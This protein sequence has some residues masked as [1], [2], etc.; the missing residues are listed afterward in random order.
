MRQIIIIFSFIVVFGCT[1]KNDKK[2]DTFVYC[3][4]G[5]PSVFNPQLATDGP[6]FNASSK[7]IYNRLTAFKPGSTEVVGELA[8]NWEVSADGKRVKFK[9]RPDVWFHEQFG[10]K[11][12][13][14]FNADDV[15]FTFNRML[16]Q[17]HPFHSVNGGSY[18]YFLSMDLGNQILELN[19]LGEHEVEFVLKSPDAPFV[20]NMAMDFASVLSKE[21]ADFLAAKNEKEKID[22]QPIGTGPYVFKKYVKDSTIRYVSHPKYFKGE[23]SIKNFV[24]AITTDATV[25]AQKLRA[26]ECHLIAEPSPTDIPTLKSEKGI[27]VTSAPG[28][29]VGYLALNVKK[30]PL[31]KAK[32][33]KAISH[34]LN[35]EKYIDS[36]YLGQAQVAHNPIPPTIWSFYKNIPKFDYNIEKAKEL[37]K[38]AGLA[39]GFSMDI[40]TL[41][42]SR[43]YNPNGKKMGE[44]MQADLAKVGIKVNLVTYDW[45]TYLAKAKAGEHD[46]I[47][48]GWTGDNGDPDNFL[49]VLLAC[50]GIEGGS[51][52]ARWCNKDFDSLTNRARMSQ[53][54]SVRTRLYE[55]AQQKFAEELPWVTLAHSKVFRAYRDNVK[56]Y[57]LNPLGTENF[58]SL[59]F[60]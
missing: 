59:S 37:L 9:L 5:S 32:V 20:A 21:Y 43:P 12:S 34:A 50:P 48:I 22:T 8:E 40:W 24:F 3:S 18:K 10:F 58:E 17:D 42:V 35:R 19:K 33:R 56:G 1:S 46:A 51:N 27:V 2:M 39:S 45:P 54:P 11:P 7:M 44:L 29:N 53:D 49:N 41:P 55:E 13:R 14:P 4:E 25:R 30:G 28:L 31:K 57:V 6:S 15:I 52:F 16:K 36:I 38:E 47:Q 60:K 23:R 26:G